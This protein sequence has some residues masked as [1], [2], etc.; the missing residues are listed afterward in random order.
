MLARNIV[1]AVATLILSGAVAWAAAPTANTCKNL[2]G[3]FQQAVK[4][5]S[6]APK[7]AMANS[8][9]DEGQKLCMAGKYKDGVAKINAAFKDL[10]LTPKM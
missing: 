1:T 7:L 6:T 8:T 5:H 9:F 10:G 2:E 4:E 3:Q